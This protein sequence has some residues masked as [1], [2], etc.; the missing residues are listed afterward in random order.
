MNKQFLRF[1]FFLLMHLTFPLTVTAQVADIPDPNLRTAV[2]KA[3]GKASGTTIT[4]ADM[5]K[6]TRLEARNANISDLTGL[7]SATNLTELHLGD[8]RVEG[9]GWINS[10]SIKDLSPLAGLTN[11]TWLNLGQNN[12][13]DLSPLAALTN[14][15]WL[16]IGGNNL[17]N[18]SPVSGLINLT[19]LRLWRN[20][21]KDISPIVDLTHL[22]ELNLDGNNISNISAV[23]GL[24]DLAKL[25]LD[26]NN[27]T[28]ISPLA[29]LTN[30]ETLDLDRNAISNI[31]PLAGLTDLTELRLQN[32]RISDISPL[33]ANTGLGSG[34]TVDVRRNPL[35]HA[36]IKI[37][38]PALQSRGVTVEFDDRLPPTIDTN[39]MVRLVYFLPNDRQARSERRSALRQLINDAQAFFADE[40]Q[41]HGYGRKTFT[42]ETDENGIP[43]VHQID[44]KFSDNYYYTGT[45]D[46]KV[47]DELVEHFAAPDALQHV[48]FIAIDLSSQSLGGGVGGLG[49]VTGQTR[50]RHRYLTE[51]DEIFGGFALIPAHGHNFERLGLTVHEL[52]HALG[53]V[54]DYRKGPHSDY[55][56]AGAKQ[57]RL[58]KCA[59]EWLSVSRFFNTKSIFHNEL[60]EIQLLSLHPYSQDAINFRFEVTDPD[61]LHQAQLLVPEI[62]NGTARGPYRLFDCKRLNSTTGTVESVVRTAELVDRITLQIIDVGGNITW[63]TFP[64]QLD[65]TVPS[66]NALDVNSDGVVNLLDLTPFISRFGQSGKH[67]ADVNEDG[68]VDIFDLLLVAALISSLP[69]HTV[70]T[71]TSSHVQKWLINAKQLEVENEILQKGIVLLEYLLAEIALLSKPMEAATG[72]LK[73]VFAGHTDHAWSVAFSHDGQTLASGSWDNTIRL[74]NPSTAQLKTTLIG[75]TDRIMSVVFSP[76]GQTLAS[77]SWDE[78]IRLWNPNTGKLLHTPADQRGAITLIAF[79]PD[80]QTLAGGGEAQPI[81]L[82]NTTTWQVERTL[83]GHTGLV[84]VVVFSSNGEILASGSRDGTIRLWNPHTAKHIRTLSTTSTVNRLAFSPDGGTLVSGSWDKTVRLW[85]P[86][87]GQLKRTL[88]NQGGWVNA[89]GFSPDGKT[90]AIGNRGISLWDLETGQYKEPL[91]EDI[92]DAISLAFSP[93]G[94]ILASGSGD[95]TVRLWDFTPAD[96]PSEDTNGDINGDGSVNVLDLVV[97]ASELGSEGQDLTADVN[98]DGAVNVLDLILVAGMFDG[99]AAAPAA[100]PQGPK[101]LT[102]VEVQGWLTDARSLE[103]RDPI[104]KRGFVVLEQLLDIPHPKRDG[105]ISKLSKSVQSRDMDSVSVGRRCSC[106]SD[107]L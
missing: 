36:S 69:P 65:E 104:M 21:I 19:A 14:L 27:I 6:L 66:Q 38:I 47:W 28:D 35:N 40:M 78:T 73:A 81:R 56:L 30:L 41:R 101:T 46:F 55:V 63:A 94:T 33:V 98:R 76:D 37:H 2:E 95:G 80:G 26:N 52:G 97:I 68:I 99:A 8:T 61:G 53:L 83:P 60:G 16:D 11:L 70:E 32:N 48:Y 22:T 93:D 50:L 20:N 100:Q 17:S 102:A 12:I 88:P 4:A 23:A 45:T 82:W 13:T 77:A 67:P 5:A 90:L 72:P 75:H 43:V 15:T 96:T 71:F 74:W 51:G 89:V 44:G 25:R 58:S 106:N 31:S 1:I 107:Y 103:V 29:G 85:N 9:E 105:T 54:H 92:G 57:N 86:H 49:G 87:T 42:V 84:E 39:G 91:A 24:T 59:A 79:S 7:E 34:D 10:N 62:L 18:I 64:I 3:L